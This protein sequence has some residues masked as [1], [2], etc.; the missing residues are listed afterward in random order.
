MSGHRMFGGA[1]YDLGAEQS[2]ALFDLYHDI[3]VNMKDV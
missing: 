3:A 1:G 2:A